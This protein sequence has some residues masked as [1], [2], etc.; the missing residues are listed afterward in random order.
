VSIM[1]PGTAC[2]SHDRLEEYFKQNG[3]SIKLQNKDVNNYRYVSNGSGKVQGLFGKKPTVNY[4]LTSNKK[5]IVLSIY[6]KY[7][8]S[9]TS[10]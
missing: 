9:Y 8:H 6:E 10:T 1:L 7:V 5:K 4:V 3:S 2:Y